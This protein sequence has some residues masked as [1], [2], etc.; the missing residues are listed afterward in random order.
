MIDSSPL[1]QAELPQAVLFDLDGTLADTA[2]DLVNPIQAMRAERGLPAL[3]F[4]S[5]RPFASMGARGLIGQGFGVGPEQA[6]FAALREEFL[7]RYEQ[8][9][10]VRT[11]LFDGMD[12]VLEALEGAGIPWGVVSNKIERYVDQI[13]VGLDLHE[14]AC[15]AV[16]GDTTAHAKPH[17][18][19]LL[20]GAR[21]AGADPTRCVYV[22]DDLRDIVAGRAASMRTVAACYGFCGGDAPPDRW[23]ADR[24]IHEP[25]QLLPLLGIARSTMAASSITGGSVPKA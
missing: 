10:L 17:P 13:L 2:H 16:G 11:R 5:L 24:L 22:G 21:L 7:H 3:P 9:M 12:V 15:C 14:R 18:E 23:E 6:Q 25:L 19:P 8:A 1:F 20:H 4:E